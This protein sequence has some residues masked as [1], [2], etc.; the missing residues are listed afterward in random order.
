MRGANRLLRPVIEVVAKIRTDLTPKLNSSLES[1][2]TL[3]SE[4][5]AAVENLV[6]LC[7]PTY[8]LP[9]VQLVRKISF[10]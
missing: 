6:R 3:A 10:R 7:P 9:R 5:R 2:C 4:L 8:V 1:D